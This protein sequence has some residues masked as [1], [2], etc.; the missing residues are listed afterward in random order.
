MC[1]RY[2]SQWPLVGKTYDSDNDVEN[3]Q[4]RYGFYGGVEV[5]GQEIEKEFRPE[6][7]FDCAS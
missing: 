2:P 4:D 5:L 3:L 1:P 6:E 7:A